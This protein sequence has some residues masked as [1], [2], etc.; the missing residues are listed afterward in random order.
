MIGMLRGVV[1][2]K[3]VGRVIL[4]VQGVG[5]NVLVTTT[6]NSRLATNDQATLFIHT[7]VREDILELY[8]FPEPQD[9]KLFELLI[10][11]SGIG[12]KTALGVFSNGTRSEI[13]NAI[14]TNNVSFFHGVPRLGQKNAQ[15]IIIELKGKFGDTGGEIDLGA[16]GS[17]ET[18]E[19]MDALTAFG[20][21]AKEAAGA[22]RS[23]NGQGAS[24]E[25]K[26]RLALKYLGK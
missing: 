15:K 5:Y 7:H 6:T 22:L 12:C 2:Y 8:G 20:F 18:T 13:I 4:D 1:A 3:D 19:V 17:S 11:V 24:T 14:L 26:I 10:G 21:S 9:L 23:L 16:D 25:E